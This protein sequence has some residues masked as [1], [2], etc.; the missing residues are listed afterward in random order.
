MRSVALILCLAPMVATAAPAQTADGGARLVQ[1]IRANGCAMTEAQAAETL[2]GLGFTMDETQA[3]V[4]H[5][6]PLGAVVLDD[7]STFD[8]QTLRLSPALCQ[9][10]PAADAAL[11]A[12]LN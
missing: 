12:G 6:V 9:A 7:A 4:V 3:Y 2:P 5:L 10:D 1:A 8:D 11:F